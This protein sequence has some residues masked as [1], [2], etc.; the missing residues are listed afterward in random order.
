MWLLAKVLIACSLVAG[1]HVGAS[2]RVTVCCE[3]AY[4]ERL[5]IFLRVIAVEAASA[6][7]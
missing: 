7:L 2:V 5:A 6:F 1:Y 3:L 4:P